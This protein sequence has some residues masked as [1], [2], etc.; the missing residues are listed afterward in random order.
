MT[1]L[2]DLSPDEATEAIAARLQ[3]GIEQAR[4]RAELVERAPE[5]ELKLAAHEAGVP[6]DH[7]V[8][9]MFLRQYDGPADPDYL[10]V[11]W[12][13]Q[14]L[15]KEPPAAVTE[16]LRDREADARITRYR[17]ALEQETT[18]NAE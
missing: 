18:E 13:R 15:D 14:V 1:D 10:I 6:L 16:R 17:Q 9:Q 4:H 5:L 11:A 7:P 8:G 3:A 2:A 12:H